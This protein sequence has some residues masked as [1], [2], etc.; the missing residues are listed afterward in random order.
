M[1]GVEIEVVVIG[2]AGESGA[3]GALGGVEFICR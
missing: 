3:C 2:R 1:G